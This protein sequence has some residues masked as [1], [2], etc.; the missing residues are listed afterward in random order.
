MVNTAWVNASRL[1]VSSGMLASS[2]SNQPSR[3]V[4]SWWRARVLAKDCRVSSKEIMA[5]AAM[6]DSSTGGLIDDLLM[7][8]Y[9]SG[10]LQRSSPKNYVMH[11]MPV[12]VSY[13][14]VYIE[15]IPSGVRTIT[16][17][18]TSIAAFVG[19]APKGP[20]DHAQR[21]LSWADYDR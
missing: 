16:G 8:T 17:V 7:P 11:P 15:E 4:C 1:G 5:A 12:Q 19:W 14:G 9:Y 13:P 21:V 10:V 20:V 2:L 18:A 3:Y 6:A